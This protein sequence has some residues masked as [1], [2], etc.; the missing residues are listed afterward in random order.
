MP[1][2]TS[3]QKISEKPTKKMASQADE[4]A[5]SNV[6]ACAARILSRWWKFLT[7][8]VT[9]TKAPLTSRSTCLV[10]KLATD[11]GTM[12]VPITLL[13]EVATSSTPATAATTRAASGTTMSLLAASVRRSNCSRGGRLAHRPAAADSARRRR[14]FCDDYPLCVPGRSGTVRTGCT[15]IAAASPHRASC[16]VSDPAGAE[17]SAQ[18]ATAAVNSAGIS[19]FHRCPAPSIMRS[20]APGI[21]LAARRA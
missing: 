10:S 20:S 19:V 1:P 9:S 11:L 5:I 7:A 2:C 16:Q 6:A 21:W 8:L 13:A 14:D 4:L 12:S 18:P 3:G 17:P 15:Y